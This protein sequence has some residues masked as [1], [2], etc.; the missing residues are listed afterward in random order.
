[1]IVI[2]IDIGGTSIK[3][4]SVN[5][6]GKI[7]D[8]FSIPIIHN[9]KQIDAV[10]R[11][12]DTVSTFINEHHYDEPISG[13]GIGVPG[14]VDIN[15]GLICYCPNLKW[16]DINLVEI[17]EKKLNLPVKITNDANAAALG[18]Y[19]FGS[20]KEYNSLIM[21]TLGT[22]V[23]GGVVMNNQLLEGN[24]GKGFELGHM[25]IQLNGRPCGCGR[26]GCFEQYASASALIYDTKLEM[27]KNK[28]SLMHQVSKEL[29]MVDARVAFIA[30]KEG[31]E[32]AIKVVNQYIAYLG[33]GLLNYCNIFRPEVIVL[34]G[35]VANEGEYLFNK[36]NEYLKEH[37]Y[38]VIGNNIPTVKV[39][40]S[41]LGYDSGKIGA[42]CLFLKK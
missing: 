27:E 26:K 40:P 9:K 12:A 6:Q 20:G 10:N 14:V 42:A 16:K 7:L 5:E 30:A 36:V 22:G 35:G 25:V 1:M 37:N 34:S 11:L 29:D 24:Q 23:G 17:L 15:K 32:S 19:V 38:G 13:I 31:D 18:E 33:E 2:G 8:K 21:I 28:N 41:T 3:G 4:A 39:V